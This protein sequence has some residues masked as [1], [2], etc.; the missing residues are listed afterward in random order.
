V[1]KRL[2][3]ALGADDVVLGGGNAKLL[4]NLPSHVRCGGNGHAFLGGHRLWRNS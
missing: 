3:A 4:K 2:R 1:T